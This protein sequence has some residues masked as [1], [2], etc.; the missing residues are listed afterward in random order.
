MR[1]H[2]H[3]PILPSSGPMVPGNFLFTFGNP[4]LAKVLL[5]LGKLFPGTFLGPWK[6]NRP[7]LTSDMRLDV[8][9]GRSLSGAGY[10]DS[11]ATR[12]GVLN[13]GWAICRV[14]RF[15]FQG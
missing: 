11:P 12:S 4:L 8:M 1:W 13:L 5:L 9:L 3:R 6:E 2:P 7:G 10:R 15:N 14:D